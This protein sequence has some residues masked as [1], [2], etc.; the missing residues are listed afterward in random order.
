MRGSQPELAI[1]LSCGVSVCI[2]HGLRTYEDVSGHRVNLPP[3]TLAVLLQPSY[4]YPFSIS[5]RYIATRDK[6]ALSGSLQ[7][8]HHP[9]GRLTLGLSVTMVRPVNQV[10]RT[11]LLITSCSGYAPQRARPA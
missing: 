6:P 5:S 3:S 2:A 7:L 8:R 4:I 1:G 10:A 11:R 9:R